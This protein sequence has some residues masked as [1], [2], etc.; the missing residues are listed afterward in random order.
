RGVL[1]A[2][3][4]E[5]FAEVGFAGDAAGNVAAG[6]EVIDEREKGIDAGVQI[7]EVGDDGDACFA[8]PG[9]GCGCCG[10]VVAVEVE[11]ASFEDPFALQVAGLD[12]ET[13]IALPG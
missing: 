10:G 5:R 9:C 13:V 11:G 3:G 1:G 12:G 8:R 7:V 2:D 6:D 4:G